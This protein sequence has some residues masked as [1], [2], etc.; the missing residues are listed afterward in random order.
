VRNGG[1][2]TT[3]THS[4]AARTYSCFN[5]RLHSTI[6]LAELMMADGPDDARPLVEIRLGELPELLPGGRVA[7][8]GLQI[9]G[10]IAML[11]VTNVGRYLVR[12]G[13]EILV[14]PAPGGSERDLRLFLLGSALGILCHQRGLL[15]LHANA[16]VAEGG[17]VAFAGHSGAGKS[18]L[19]A[20][21]QRAGYEV[22]C[23]DVC[24]ISF[25][26]AGLPCAWP[27]LPRLKLWGDAAAAFGHDSSTLDQAI[28]GMDKY[29]VPMAAAGAARPIPFRRLYVLSRADDGEAGAIARLRGQ[30]ALEAV[31][32]QTYRGAYLGPMGLTE[33]HFRQ[34][35]ALLAHAEIYAA[36]RAWG[37]DV[38]DREAQRLERH[39]FDAA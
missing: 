16:I 7:G 5:F 23:D 31:M 34:C 32:A 2:V 14:D 11:T 1:I 37:Y 33:R 35:M 36:S 18:T 27:G 4:P 15:P 38:F 30:N 10:D 24:M 25:D 21:F 20:H 8:H 29:H 12:A 17:A 9:A 13:S 3:R 28:E 39:I 19:A 22:L 26:E 6:P